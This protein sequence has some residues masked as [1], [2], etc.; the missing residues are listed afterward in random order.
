[1]KLFKT[2]PIIGQQA[3]ATFNRKATVGIVVDW[4]D[5]FPRGFCR[6]RHPITGQECDFAPESVTL[7]PLLAEEK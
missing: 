4:E 1:M 7:I 3:I 5:N 2:E 6:V